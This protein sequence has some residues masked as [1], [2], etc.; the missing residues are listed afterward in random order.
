MTANLQKAGYRLVV[1]DL[2]H[3]T[4]AALIAKG[5]VWAA[6]PREVA[7]KC[8][9]VFTCLPNIAVIEDVALGADGLLPESA[10]IRPFSRCRP[11]PPS[12]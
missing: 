6:S 3:E 8:E 5:A 2:K 7:E 1:N 4:A 12:F 10:R 9:V 11:I